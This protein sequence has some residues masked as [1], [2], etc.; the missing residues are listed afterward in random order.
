MK[1][2]HDEE[3]KEIA[4]QAEKVAEKYMMKE[5]HSEVEFTDYEFTPMHTLM[6]YG[7]FKKN[8]KE[9]VVQMEKNG[10]KLE[11]GSYAKQ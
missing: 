7:N 3:E 4:A 8:N 1:H 9:I 2:K 6:L 11:A 5:E 10:H